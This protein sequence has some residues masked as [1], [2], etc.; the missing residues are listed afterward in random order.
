[1]SDAYSDFVRNLMA[2]KGSFEANTVHAALGIAGEAGEV[3]DIIKKHFAY[4][5]EVDMKKLTEEI[6]DLMFYI[7]ALCN[8]IGVPPE[9]IVKQ[10]M[11][12]LSARYHTGTFT[13]EQA[14]A[15]ADKNEPEQT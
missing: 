8:F 4:G 5:K 7:Q 10:N 14:I 15:R 2:D 13:A 6:G 9:V 1:M 12:K 3:V 11:A